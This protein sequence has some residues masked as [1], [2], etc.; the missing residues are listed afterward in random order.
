MA[1]RADM[2]DVLESSA[3]AGASGANST[4]PLISMT[5]EQLQALLNEAR[6][7]GGNQLKE[8]GCLTKFPPSPESNGK[9]E[10][11]AREV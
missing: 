7:A 6:A 9:G 5:P 1:L 8:H 10:A 3:N 11:T 4:N 2:D